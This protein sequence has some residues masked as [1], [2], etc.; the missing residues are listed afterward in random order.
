MKVFIEKVN[1]NDLYLESDGIQFTLVSYSGK[2]VTD[3]KTGVER[4][5]CSV[6]GYYSAI[7]A[8]IKKAIKLVI[9]QSTATTLKELVDDLH[10]IEKLVDEKI[11]G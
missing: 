7:N 10:R 6:L 5:V 11:N 9:M 3:K 8:A 1:G 2:T 4:E